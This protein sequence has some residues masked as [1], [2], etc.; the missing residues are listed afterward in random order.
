M[1]NNFFS[2]KQ[3]TVYQDKCAMK[4]GTDGVLLGAWADIPKEGRI[5]DVGTGT[6]LIAMMCAQRSDHVQV[7]AVEI[8]PDAAGQA[9]ENCSK[10]PWS[11][12]IRVVN[13]SFQS[14][15][16]AI[17]F[18]YDLI[19]S[20]PPFFRDSLRPPENTRS[21][22]RHDEN[23]SPDVLF[24]YAFSLINEDSRISLIYPAENID[25][26]I[27]SAFFSGL[28]P[29]RKT[30][31]RPVEGRK[32]SRCLIEFSSDSSNHCVNSEIAIK[33]TKNE[34]TESYR[35]LTRDFYLKF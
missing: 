20:N 9:A 33:T 34:C 5:L 28:Y 13:D 12:R 15:T 29:I 6:G 17:D 10:L 2:F 30:F 14:F 31:V 22:A 11:N 26:L 19:I 3:F 32:F 7:D 4:V 35:D 21:W 8:D 24:H 25:Y 18:K 23:L 27:S 1:S 16:E